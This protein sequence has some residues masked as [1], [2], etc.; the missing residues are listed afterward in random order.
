MILALFH[1]AMELSL[2]GF[3]LGWGCLTFYPYFYCI[4]LWAVADQP[5]D[6][7]FVVHDRNN[8]L[9][10]HLNVFAI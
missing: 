6:V 5:D 4:G 1:P 3:K 2:Q 10:V 9:I 7:V 8:E